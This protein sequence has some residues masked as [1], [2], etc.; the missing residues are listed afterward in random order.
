MTTNVTTDY[1]VPLETLVETVDKPSFKK[2]LF[3]FYAEIA[4][5]FLI[6]ILFRQSR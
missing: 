3:C 5:I 1:S 4:L 2:L 6:Y